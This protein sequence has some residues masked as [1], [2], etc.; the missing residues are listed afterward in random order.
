MIDEEEEKRKDIFL[1]AKIEIK[2]DKIVVDYS[3]SDRQRDRQPINV[4]YS[5]TMADTF[6][7]FNIYF[8]EKFQI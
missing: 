8:L 2:K 4:P 1:K 6:M 5:Y 3:G 7:L